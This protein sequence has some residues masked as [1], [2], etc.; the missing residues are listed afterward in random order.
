MC[1]NAIPHDTCIRSFQATC[2]RKGKGSRICSL[3]ARRHKI[4]L[5]YNTKVGDGLIKP[6]G[7]V[8]DT[9]QIGTMSV[10]DLRSVI[11]SEDD[12]ERVVMLV[13]VLWESKSKRRD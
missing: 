10:G 2:R 7:F 8:R 9:S 12:I 4:Y 3:E 1:R 13:K 6:S 5:T 11:T